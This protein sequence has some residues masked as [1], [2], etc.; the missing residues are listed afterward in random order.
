MGNENNILETRH[1]RSLGFGS[2][3]KSVTMKL[4][5]TYSLD[6]RYMDLQYLR[7]FHAI[8]SVM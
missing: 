2:L 7:L 4:P 8:V 5:F 3:E 6:P 1:I